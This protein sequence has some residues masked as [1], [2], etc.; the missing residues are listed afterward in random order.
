LITS[1]QTVLDSKLE[2]WLVMLQRLEGKRDDV[3]SKADATAGA[4]L[5]AEDSGRADLVR[6][7]DRCKLML[8][9]R[10]GQ[11]GDVEV[12]VTL[13]SERLELGVE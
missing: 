5:V 9:Q 8:I 4:I 13:I 11:V 6:S 2:R 10:L 7:E 1:S 12:G 3:P